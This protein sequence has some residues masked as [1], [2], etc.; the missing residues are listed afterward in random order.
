[1]REG[2]RAMGGV[3]VGERLQLPEDEEGG[4]FSGG[5]SIK[6]NNLEILTGLARRRTQGRLP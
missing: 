3:F 6:R 5:L 2:F 1:M 4:I